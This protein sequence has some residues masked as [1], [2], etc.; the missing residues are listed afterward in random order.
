MNEITLPIVAVITIGLAAAGAV[1]F[2]VRVIARN[3]E[4][5]VKDKFTEAEK[6]RANDQQMLRSDLVKLKDQVHAIEREL[7]REYV[8]RDDHIEAMATVTA[9]IDAVQAQGAHLLTLVARM[10]GKL[11]HD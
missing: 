5:S 8:R 6:A 1:A 10:E 4:T 7:P 3:F 2:L 9:K 11:N